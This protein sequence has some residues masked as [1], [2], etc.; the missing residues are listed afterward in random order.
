MGI[1]VLVGTVLGV[2]ST[3]A[4]RV[5]NRFVV[6]T[7]LPSETLVRVGVDPGA[8]LACVP[9]LIAVCAWVREDVKTKPLKCMQILAHIH[10]H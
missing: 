7:R 3:L 4:G 10:V 6:R 9:L 5:Q 1:P 8:L 2:Y